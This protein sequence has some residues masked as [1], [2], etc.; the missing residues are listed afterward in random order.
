MKKIIVTIL[1]FFS[2]IPSFSQV[3]HKK[4]S[5]YLYGQYNKT[6]Y[7]RT[8]GNNPWGLG[9]GIQT[10]FNNNSKFK[11]AIELTADA[12]LEDDKVFRANTDGTSIPDVGGMINFF[13]GSS[14]HL[15]KTI[16]LSLMTGSSFVSRQVLL[17]LK[18]SIGFYFLEDRKWTAKVSYINIFDRDEITK[19]DFG[20]LSISV[21]LKIF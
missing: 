19:E 15:T 11:P 14:F 17:G 3:I 2:L 5:T 7:D 9:L 21:G 20:S 16:Y 10:L 4:V 12:Y 6:I 1:F 18:P 13:V 8:L